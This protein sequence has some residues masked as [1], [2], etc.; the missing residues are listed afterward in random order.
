[1]SDSNA[2]VIALEIE[3]SESGG[4]L[5]R[6]ELRIETVRP[7]DVG[8]IKGIVDRMVKTMSDEITV[9]RSRVL[10]GQERLPLEMVR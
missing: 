10:A 7:I 4:Q 1:M 5:F 8:M 2:M 3:D 6:Q 9:E